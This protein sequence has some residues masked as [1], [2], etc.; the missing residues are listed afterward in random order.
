[1]SSAWRTPPERRF[2]ELLENIQDGV[3]ETSP[4]GEIL[5]A[6]AVGRWINQNDVYTKLLTGP[7]EG[8]LHVPGRSTISRPPAMSNVSK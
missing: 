4:E 6:P 5:R 8:Q 7:T 3:Y 1:M 2:R